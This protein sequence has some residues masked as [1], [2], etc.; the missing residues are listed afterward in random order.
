[1]SAYIDSSL[2]QREFET[3]LLGL[4]SVLA[5]LLAAVGIYGLLAYTVAQRTHE[6][7]IRM[8]LG[9]SKASV[10]SSVLSAGLRLT[11]CGA[12]IGLAISLAATRALESLLFKVNGQDPLTLVAATLLLSF[13]ATVACW[14]PAKRAIGVDPIVA[15]RYE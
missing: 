15:L 1:M 10:L 8:A 5:L 12:A 4:F 13:V 6:F 11:I 14:V 2:A 9:A 3:V 7:G